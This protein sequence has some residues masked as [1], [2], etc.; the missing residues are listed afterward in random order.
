M[1]CVFLFSFLCQWLLVT[2][3][4][5][6]RVSQEESWFLKSSVSFMCQLAAVRLQRWNNAIHC[7]FLWRSAGRRALGISHVAEDSGR[8]VE[9]VTKEN[10]VQNGKLGIETRETS[11]SADSME[12]SRGPRWWEY[13][14]LVQPRFPPQLNYFFDIMLV[15]ASSD[16]WYR[17]GCPVSKQV[18]LGT[19]GDYLWQD[20]EENVWIRLDTWVLQWYQHK[21]LAHLQ[22]TTTQRLPC[23]PPETCVPWNCMEG[24]KNKN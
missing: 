15:H 5:F 12:D 2:E 3:A 21:G 10:N 4:S 22:P 20:C 24:R 6:L 7:N 17:A 18:L 11:S 16:V 19:Q 14:S 8:W 13:L 9:Q 1:A 23:M